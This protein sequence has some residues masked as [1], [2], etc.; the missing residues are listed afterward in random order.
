MS[1]PLAKGMPAMFPIMFANNYRPQRIIIGRPVPRCFAV[2]PLVMPAPVLLV[3]RTNPV[4]P[5]IIIAASVVVAAGIALYENEQFRVWFDERRRQI[6]VAFHDFGDVV[7]PRSEGSEPASEASRQRRLD[8]VRRNR[9]MLMRR[10]REE[11]IAV[12]LDELASLGYSGRPEM[13]QRRESNT[14]FDDF[15]S[16]DGKLKA[17]AQKAQASGSEAQSS[18]TIRQR[19][20]GARGLAAGSTFANPFEDEAHILDES[21]I[22]PS[23]GEIPTQE[24]PPSSIL[25]LSPRPASTIPSIID[26]P[27]QDSHWSF[28]T[29][30]QPQYKTDD[31]LEAE[32]QEA[33]RLSLA[34]SAS[35]TPTST[36]FTP[37]SFDRSAT[38]SSATSADLEGLDDSLYALPSPRVHPI[39]AYNPPSLY[40]TVGELRPLEE[41]RSGNQTPVQST[42]TLTPMSDI[43]ANFS[44][45]LSSTQRSATIMEDV[46][47]VDSDELF[48]ARSEAGESEAFSLVGGASTP[49]S[50]TD[51]DTDAEGEDMNGSV[52]VRRQVSH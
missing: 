23:E 13:E 6:A 45:A 48:D 41:P 27:I 5:G 39:D 28:D 10:A 22:A 11:G 20:A 33:I 35:S 44:D 17:E 38:L 3:R 21:L 47:S 24:Y 32:I 15:V 9:E 52:A 30:Q 8:I 43:S 50:W 25:T 16:P 19:G 26:I 12:D 40:Q 49:G 51:V 4:F 29:V 42:G 36:N 2:S 18:T 46:Q 1:A 34:E 14:S 7:Q 37:A 31:E